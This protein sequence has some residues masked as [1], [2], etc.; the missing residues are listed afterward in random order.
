MCSEQVK[1]HPGRL[2]AG[3]SSPHYTRRLLPSPAR[4][5]R[6]LA[7]GLLLVLIAVIA[8]FL[9]RIEAG[10]AVV[11]VAL[12]QPLGS[13]AMVVDSSTHRAF[14]ATMTQP[15]AAPPVS[16]I[17]MLD[18]RTASVL[19]TIEV[20]T[21]LLPLA[22]DERLDRLVVASSTVVNSGVV[23]LLDGR[24]GAIV[25]SAALQQPPISLAVNGRAARIYVAVGAW[26]TCSTTACNLQPTIVSVL[27]AHTL[28]LLHTETLSRSLGDLRVDEYRGRVFVPTSAGLVVLDAGGRVQRV[29]QGLAVL[30]IDQRTG[31]VMITTTDGIAMLDV[32]TG[33]LLWRR[34]ELVS[35]ATVDGKSG[36]VLVLPVA[37]NT[38]EVLSSTTG[39]VLHTVAVGKLPVAIVVDSRAGRAYVANHDDHSISLLDTASWRVQRTVPVAPYPLSV[40]LDSAA[41]RVIVENTSISVQRQQ[42]MQA[43]IP[44]ALRQ[45]LPLQPGASLGAISPE[46]TSSVSVV[47]V[48]RL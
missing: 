48:S 47:D 35:A 17:V 15:I 7:I 2:P 3:S 10:D 38:V 39:A 20:G 25:R 36:S 5:R 16:R 12:G 21:N 43:W 9:I 32:D 23:R 42:G 27:D 26:S 34:Q 24:T 22:L 18:T 46:P 8:A 40:S 44:A 14:V 37:T 41:H 19:K 4:L 29:L 11:T 33:R 28:R 1:T 31:H 13:T 30:A 45:W 6:P